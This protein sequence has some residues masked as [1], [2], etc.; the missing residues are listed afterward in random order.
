MSWC[1]MTALEMPMSVKAWARPDHDQGHGHDAEIRGVEELGQHRH[2]EVLELGSEQ[3]R[4][5]YPLDPRYR[6]AP[7]MVLL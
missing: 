3:R 7:E 2:L 6:M 1:W 4:Q 5:A